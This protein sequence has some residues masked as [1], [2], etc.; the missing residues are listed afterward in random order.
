MN[1]VWQAAQSFEPRGIPLALARSI[2]A[3]AQLTTVLLASDRTLFANPPGTTAGTRCAGVKGISLWCVSGADARADTLGRVLAIA[4]LLVVIVGYRPRWSCVAHYYIAFS[5][6]VDVTATNGGD[7]VAEILT[8]LLVPICLDDQ[9]SWAWRK[10]TSPLQPAWRGGAFAAHAALR[11]QIA[12]IYLGAAS[13]KLAFPAW[14]HGTALGILAHDPE[15]GFPSVLQPFTQQLLSHA[16]GTDLLTWSALV[17]ETLIA[18][19]MAFRRR[20]RRYGL[21][22]AIL[23]H[24]A[25][26]I[27]MGLFSF[28]LIMIALVLAACA[29]VPTVRRTRIHIRQE[30]VIAA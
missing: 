28:G 17:I 29:D 30:T 9:R 23:L 1:R 24:G 5:V 11:C 20:T 6:A 16:W 18:L 19:S 27:L 22:L 21:V 13:S 10:P 15:F 25:I 8:M 26:A 14:R 12:I 4:V 2:L 7:N 3:F